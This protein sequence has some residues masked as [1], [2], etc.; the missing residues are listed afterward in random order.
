MVQDPT[1]QDKQQ[2]NPGA[3]P[4]PGKDAPRSKFTPSFL[5]RL[6]KKP[7]KLLLLSAVLLIGGGT[8]AYLNFAQ[9]A[10]RSLLPAGTQLVPQTAIATMTLTTDEL[11]W[12]K[13]R[14]FGT[15]ETQQQFDGLLSAWKDRLF[16]LNGYSFKR[17][18]K[19]WIGD[20]VTLAVLTDKDA[21]GDSASESLG[22][23]DM[24]AQ[25]LVL[26]IPIDDPLKAKTLIGEGPKASS[27]TWSDRTYKGVDIKTIESKD[28]LAIESAVIGSSWL[29]LSNS[30]SGIEQAI[31]THKGGRSLLDIAGY[32]KAATRVESPQPPGKNFAQIYLNIPAATQAIAPSS[33]I[34]SNRNIIPLQGSQGIVANALIESEGIRF[35]GTSWLDPKNDLAY[36]E[37]SNAAGKM[38]RRLPDDTLIMA[39]G[40]NLQKFWQGFSESNSSPPFF[41]NPQNLKAGLLTQTGL[42]LDEDIMPW[43][44]GEFALGVLPPV[45]K[46]VPEQT[47]SEDSSEESSEPQLAEPGIENAPLLMMVQTN[48]RQLAES[49][50]A[51]LDDVM[52]SRYR[53]QV[54]T[55]EFEGGSVTEWI[56]PFQGVQFSHGWL[57]GNVAFFAMGADAVQA[58]A[59]TPTR[60][61][62]A[63]R[64]FQTLTSQAPEP[65]NGHFYLDLTTINSLAGGVFPLPALPEDGPTAAIEAIGMTTVI[66]DGKASP[67]DRRTMDYDLYVKL[68]KAAK[69]GPL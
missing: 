38:P 37:L 17:D 24:A 32:R 42:D 69:P 43:A 19:P 20:R 57:P 28:G 3:E 21:S 67:T 56:S 13:L 55:R 49:T 61:L 54:N 14:Q 63:N 41:P 1:A 16:T 59:P 68:S 39:S 23:I 62:A 15:A 26:V 10:P 18:I 4:T 33:G 66:G 52:A 11:T 8:V 47:P 31:D 48:D 2:E 5:P 65:N 34:G 9:R 45:Q 35:Q 44:A 36:S 22:G 25:N 50:W 53:Y 6:L 64:L 27:I 40:S 29:L 51:Q 7:P 58:I 60:P 12:T 46:A 30:Q